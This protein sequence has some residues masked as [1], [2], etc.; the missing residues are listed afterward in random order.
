MASA[1][2][3]GAARPQGAAIAAA[4]AALSGLAL[5]AAAVA[6]PRQAVLAV[7]GAALGLVLY[8]SGFGFASGWRALW[9]EGDA[10][11]ARAQ[12]VLLAAT[13][14]L[15]LP[16]LALGPGLGLAV[17]GYVFPAGPVVALGGFLFGLGMQLAGGCASGTLYTV[18]GGSPRM[19]VVLLAFVAGSVLGTLHLPSLEKLPAAPPL[20]LGAALGWPLALLL[21]LAPLL[22][23]ERLLARRAPPAGA[24]A[25]DP[26]IRAALA[27][28]P[29][30]LAVLL[31]SGRPWG[32]TSAFALWGGKALAAAGLPVE[33][34]PGFAARAGELA[35]P[36]LAD[37][38]SVTNLGIALGALLAA[39]LAGRL[40]RRPW[41]EPR[42][43]LAALLGGL[44]LG[45]GARLAQ[46]CNIGAFLSGIASGSPHGW[47]GLAA[48][49]AATPLGLGLRAALGLDRPAAPGR[50]T[51]AP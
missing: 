28:A 49:L 32:I 40:R 17:E 2:G 48:A 21:T 50:P 25:S 22:A 12:L 42:E 9:R 29:L 39:G 20:A 1:Q 5:A 26:R 33:G 46:G 41:P 31:V 19:A 4:A 6:G 36:L 47:L 13:A 43:L 51:A 8:R 7:L 34:W 3:A 14:A 16:T 10:G 24:P 11:S 37:V 45:Y 15:V 30:A 38:T 27:L 44:L 23:L 35:A 18:G